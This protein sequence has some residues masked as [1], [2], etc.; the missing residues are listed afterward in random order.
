[1]CHCFWWHICFFPT[2][3]SQTKKAK[4]PPSQRTVT[5]GATDKQA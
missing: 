4:E 1:M 2:A 3:Q 5:A